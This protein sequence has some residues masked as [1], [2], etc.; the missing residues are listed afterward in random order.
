MTRDRV[1]VFVDAQNLERTAAHH[2]D[3]EVVV[4]YAE[5]LDVLVGDRDLVR[6]YCFDSHQPDEGK[7]DFYRFLRR[8]LGFR[9]VSEPLE[10]EGHPK[11][12]GV[13]VALASELIENQGGNP[14]HGFSRGRKPTRSGHIPRTT[15]GRLLTGTVAINCYSIHI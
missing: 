2:Y 1:M 6:P 8:E 12:K 14:R 13:D 9:V 10:T 5:L 7:D 11:E 4:D 15:T 3:E